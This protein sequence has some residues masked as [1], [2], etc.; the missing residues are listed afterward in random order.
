M[1][2]Q[3]IFSKGLSCASHANRLKQQ[4]NEKGNRGFVPLPCLLALVSLV[5]ATRE[6]QAASIILAPPAGWN[7]FFVQATIEAGFKENGGSGSSTTTLTAACL[8]V[9][10]AE[11]SPL[12]TG[13]EFNS[14]PISLSIAPSDLA[15]GSGATKDIA[16]GAMSFTYKLGGTAA[17]S[18]DVLSFTFAGRT[19][20]VNAYHDF[21]SG[22]VAADAYF[23]AT[24]TTLCYGPIPASFGATFK[25]PA[26][27]SLTDPTQE[28]ILARSF[29]SGE[30]PL[31]YL[32]ATQSAGDASRSVSIT[33]SDVS[34]SFTYEMIYEIRTPFG[35][36]PDFTYQFIG[37]SSV[38]PECH[39]PLLACAA[40][41]ILF[42]SRRRK[43]PI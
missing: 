40:S 7:G 4:S 26:L 39:T 2:K 14:T 12:S 19:S 11:G 36:D 28:S 15:G 43:S 24:L 27:P 32:L 35:T 41:G 10:Y 33:M 5:A 1:K 18:E 13:H 25:M 6:A 17:G 30:T 9:D 34:S 29:I 20:A 3:D 23:K 38:I 21:G 8:A 22:P 31:P 16:S 42:L 37:G